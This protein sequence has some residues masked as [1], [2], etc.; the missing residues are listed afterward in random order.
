MVQTYIDQLNPRSKR[1]LPRSAS[2]GRGVSITKGG[3]R[4]TD[5]K[6]DDEKPKSRVGE[7]DINTLIE[8]K[9][10]FEKSFLKDKTKKGKK[11]H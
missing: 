1:K 5:N 10:I 4:V 2:E 8:D 3:E 7:I 6:K 11:K 9:D